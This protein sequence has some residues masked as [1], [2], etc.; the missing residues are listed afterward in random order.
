MEQFISVMNGA[1]FLYRKVQVQKKSYM[2][3]KKYTFRGKELCSFFLIIDFLFH[4]DLL[5]KES[6]CLL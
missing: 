6:T 3:L 2:K 5:L 4:G 1:Y